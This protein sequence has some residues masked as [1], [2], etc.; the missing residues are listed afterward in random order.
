[1]KN[2]LNLYYIF[3]TA[4]KCGSISL[5]AKE[6]FISQPAV[7]KAISK[8]EESFGTKLFMRGSR[9]VTLTDSGKLL[10]QQ[11]ETAFYAIHAGEEQL[12]KNEALGV[13]KLSIGVSTTLCKYVL[14]PYL[15]EFIRQNPHIKISIS[16]QPSHETI[17]A[18]ENGQ[19]DGVSTTLCKYVLLPYLKEFI[20]QNPHI[21]I[22]ISCQPSHETIAALENGQLDIG[23]VGEAE[24]TGLSFHA[25]RTISDVFVANR[26]Y[27]NLLTERIYS[28]KKETILADREFFS[29][30]TLLL[31]NR[32]NMSRQLVDKYML[33][34]DIA[35]E[36]QVE[37]STMDL[38]ID[39]AKI[40]MGI[41]C[42]TKDFVE[43]ELKEGSLVLVSTR[44]PIPSR[45]IGF[46]YGERHIT[47]AMEK[48]LKLSG[49][50]FPCGISAKLPE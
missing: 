8:L 20:R 18:L 19:L 2:Q 31:L 42:V 6:L 37:V 49:K 24:N 29:H 27:L 3:C 47:P 41:A 15:K 39:F 22:S 14:L 7:S 11:L 10:F 1:M 26:D 46:S 44:E 32:G 23:L 40:G 33:L 45:Q 28:E 50:V 36:Q 4:A 13:G 25:L 48:F 30:A 38:L 12:V 34:Q 35:S 21:K 17:A 5:A 43:K 16:C 9:G